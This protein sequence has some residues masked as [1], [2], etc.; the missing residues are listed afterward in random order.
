MGYN[1]SIQHRAL[2]L[3][4]GNVSGICEVEAN[5][6]LPR[7]IDPV[8]NIQGVTWQTEGLL[9]TGKVA[10]ICIINVGI[11]DGKWLRQLLNIDDYD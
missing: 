8:Q 3:S 1:G 6:R 2:Q 10:S 11:T 7:W 4:L 5:I 9:I